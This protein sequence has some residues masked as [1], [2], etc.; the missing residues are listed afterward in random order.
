MPDIKK[1]TK[2]NQIKNEIKKD[3][4]KKNKKK[5][6]E[7]TEEQKEELKEKILQQ[8][9]KEYHS[10]VFKKIE[11]EVKEALG[12]QKTDEALKNITI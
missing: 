1:N 7:L 12:K 10:N 9:K 4:L 5:V 8:D 2:K 6:N 11:N 3:D